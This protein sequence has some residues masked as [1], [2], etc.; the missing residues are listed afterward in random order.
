MCT[1]LSVTCLTE[2]NMMLMQ[3]SCIFMCQPM[4]NEQNAIRA[5]TKARERKGID[6]D[7][8]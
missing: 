4:G 8:W 6:G 2:N 1:G 5:K 7:G 3:L